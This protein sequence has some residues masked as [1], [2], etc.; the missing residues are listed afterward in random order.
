MKTYTRDLVLEGITE[1]DFQNWKHHPVTK[2]VRRYHRDMERY[3]A[4]HQIAVLRNAQKGMSDL[5]QG[6]YKGTINTHKASAELEYATIADFYPSDEQQ[7]DE[8]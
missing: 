3:L 6:E 1:A 8:S 4:E 2:L 7:E 5:E